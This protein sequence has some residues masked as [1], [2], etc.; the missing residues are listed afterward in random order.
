MTAPTRWVSW[1]AVSTLPQA[2]KVS[3]ED[4][5][6]ENR[7]HAAK[8]GGIVLEEL[9]VPGESRSIVLL[10]DA[11]ARIPAYARLR[12]LIAAKAFDVLVYLDRSRLGRKAALSMAIIELCHDAGILAYETDNPPASLAAAATVGTDDMLI[13]AIKSVGAQSEIDKFK[14]RSAMG[15]KARAKAGAT[16]GDLPELQNQYTKAAANLQKISRAIKRAL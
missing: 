15:R 1:A 10:E 9:V 11:A 7:A 5:L 8:H 4:Q 13:G 2:K 3:N 12:E 16:C 14:R 6:R